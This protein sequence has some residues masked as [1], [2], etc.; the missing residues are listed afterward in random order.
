VA[1][2]AH[3]EGELLVAN[4]PGEATEGLHVAD[5]VFVGRVDGAAQEDGLDHAHLIERV[6]PA[7]EEP[8]HRAPRLLQAPHDL[9]RQGRPYAVAV[10]TQ[11]SVLLQQFV[12][13]GLGDG[14]HGLELGVAT[15][16]VTGY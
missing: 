10:H 16:L 13:A 6:D 9:D 12:H 15:E 11:G 14:L 3:D 5:L 8:L 4:G 7:N 2:G 1:E